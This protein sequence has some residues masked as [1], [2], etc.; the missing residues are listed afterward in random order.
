MQGNAE[1]G[2][3]KHAQEIENKKSEMCGYKNCSGN[4]NKS[5]RCDT[6]SLILRSVSRKKMHFASAY[7]VRSPVK[8]QRPVSRSD[9]LHE[10][11][12]QNEHNEF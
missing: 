9:D 10:A 4:R 12:S 2:E 7:L 11:S 6:V 5:D 1:K 8:F 3:Y